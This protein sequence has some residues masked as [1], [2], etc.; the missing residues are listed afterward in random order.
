MEGDYPNLA[1]Y[2]TKMKTNLT[3]ASA[4]VSCHVHN[5]NMLFSLEGR[6]ASAWQ[7][8]T[9]APSTAPDTQRRDRMLG[10]TTGRAAFIQE[11]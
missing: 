8:C 3:K 1:L 9:G 10:M 2:H 11:L 7:S 5:K 4:S 6:L